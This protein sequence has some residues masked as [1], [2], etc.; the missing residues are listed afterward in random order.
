VYLRSKTDTIPQTSYD[1]YEYRDYND[2]DDL[3]AHVLWTIEPAICKSSAN[4]LSALSQQKPKLAAQALMATLD[5][6]L[7]RDATRMGS[8]QLRRNQHL[9]DTEA[10]QATRDITSGGTHHYCRHEPRSDATFKEHR[11]TWITV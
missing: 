11:K 1:Y 10:S 8:Y 4:E 3:R 9:Y 2:Y 6:D 5:E 7:Q